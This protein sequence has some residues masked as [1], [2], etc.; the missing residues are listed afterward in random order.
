MVL[1]MKH[2]LKILFL[3]VMQWFY[4]MSSL[5]EKTETDKDRIAFIFAG[6]IRSFV[7]PF[8]HE[9]LRHNLIRA[10]CPPS[11]CIADVFVRISSS[12]NTHEKSGANAAG[13]AIST[14][15]SHAFYFPELC[16]Y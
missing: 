12:D 4:L 14:F 7:F 16:Y 5:S 6:S 1:I 15:R 8:V 2:S 9:S 10:F 13:M 11:K 3:I